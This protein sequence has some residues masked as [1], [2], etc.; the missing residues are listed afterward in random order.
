VPVKGLSIY[1]GRPGRGRGKVTASRSPVLS[2]EKL[3]TEA[4]EVCMTRGMVIN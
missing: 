2:A 3:D 1:V 4:D